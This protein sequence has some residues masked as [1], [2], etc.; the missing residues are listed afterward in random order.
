MGRRPMSR[1]RLRTITVAVIATAVA[2]LATLAAHATTGS[3]RAEGGWSTM[4]TSFADPGDGACE[5]WPGDPG[6]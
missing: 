2:G 4:C 6:L 3:P 5:E 1:S